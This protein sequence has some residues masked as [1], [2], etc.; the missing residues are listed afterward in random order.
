MIEENA[1]TRRRSTVEQVRGEIETMIKESGLKPGDRLPSE[2]ELAIR[3]GVSRSSIR[4]ALKHLEEAGSVSAIHGRGRFL[5]PVGGLS[6]ERPITRFESITQMLEAQGHAVAR[7]VLDVHIGEAEEH[8]ASALGVESGADVIRLIRLFYGDEQPIVLS[9]ATVRREL[10]PGPVEYRDWS[11]SL[12][13]LLNVH[14]HRL[15]SSAARIRAVDLPSEY[16]ARFSLTGLGPWLLIEETCLSSSG[17]RILYSA[18]YHRGSFAA[19][20]MVRQV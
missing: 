20:S 2:S 16:E 1:G 17:E 12:T 7:A 4:E 18:D 10:L 3:F 9:C 6:V 5:S 8:E 13:T 11:G 14:G 19:F 15:V